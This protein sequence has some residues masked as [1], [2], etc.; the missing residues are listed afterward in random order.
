M[1]STVQILHTPSQD[2]L[3]LVYYP[4]PLSKSD[5]QQGKFQ[6]T[7]PALSQTLSH[8]SF[9]LK[10]SADCIMPALY[11]GVGAERDC[12]SDYQNEKSQVLLQNEKNTYMLALE[13]G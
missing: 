3:I 9:M 11:T 13:A 5:Y 6:I 7:V 12:H 4:T 1:V 8:P 10:L 2:L